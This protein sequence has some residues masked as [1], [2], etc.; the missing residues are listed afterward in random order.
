MNTDEIWPRSIHPAA[1]GPAWNT[2][3][4]C[5]ADAYRAIQPGERVMA[6]VVVVQD[7]EGRTATVTRDQD[8]TRRDESATGRRE[9]A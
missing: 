4:D 2:L 5:S 3:L 9:V 1:R 8:G 6:V 7:A